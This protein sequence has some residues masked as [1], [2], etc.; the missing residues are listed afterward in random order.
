MRPPLV[1]DNVRRIS[2]L[3]PR[4]VERLLLLWV[5]EVQGVVRDLLLR[6]L[7]MVSFRTVIVVV[8]LFLMSF[9]VVLTAILLRGIRP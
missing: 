8:F 6:N 7:T 1:L 4:V 3:L 2:L 9:R 5:A